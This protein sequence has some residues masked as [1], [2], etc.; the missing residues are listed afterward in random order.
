V[1]IVT[2]LNAFDEEPAVVRIKVESPDD[3]APFQR[4]F[5]NVYKDQP[6]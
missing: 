1:A 5:R 4:R 6:D 2:A 3:F